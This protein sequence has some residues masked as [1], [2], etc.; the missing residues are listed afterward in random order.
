MEVPETGEITDFVVTDVDKD[1]VPDVVLVSSTEKNMIVFA[2]EFDPATSTFTS[3]SPP[4]PFGPETPEKTMK[5]A[6]EDIDGDGFPDIVVGQYEAPNYILYGSPD[7]PGTFPEYTE[8]GA[9]ETPED[10]TAPTYD[11]TTDVDV[12]DLDGDGVLDVVFANYDEDNKVLRASARSTR[13]PFPP[14]ST[15]PSA[16]PSRTG[17]TSTSPPTSTCRRSARPT[18]PLPTS[19]A[20]ASSTS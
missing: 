17:S 20:T 3:P 14:P 9:P 4:S 19:P 11:K 12:A 16:W 1:D 10:G 6:V 8:I 18:S 5:V 2:P 7:S 15:P 13:P